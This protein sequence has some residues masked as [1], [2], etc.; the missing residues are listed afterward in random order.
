MTRLRPGLSG[1]PLIAGAVADHADGAVAAT[2]PRFR[3]AGYYE[4]VREAVAREVGTDARRGSRHQRGGGC[5]LSH[6]AR[7]LDSQTCAGDVCRIW[8]PLQIASL[9]VA[10][11]S[12][13]EYK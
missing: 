3:T 13:Q 7:D 10:R 6:L 1:S 5:A 2:Y 11:G 12:A 4:P 8:R 9:P